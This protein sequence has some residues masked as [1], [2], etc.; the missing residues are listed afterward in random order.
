ME[1]M[2]V[3]E[4]WKVYDEI[5][6][7]GNSIEERLAYLDRFEEEG[8]FQRFSDYQNLVDELRENSE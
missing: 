7:S 1:R 3:E 8:R 5:T 2:T 4:F 6:A